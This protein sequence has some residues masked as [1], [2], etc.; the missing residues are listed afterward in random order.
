MQILTTRALDAAA[1]EPLLGS[2]SSGLGTGPAAATA[3]APAAAKPSVE[4]LRFAHHFGA[5]IRLLRPYPALVLTL[6][7]IAEAYVVAEG[8]RGRGSYCML[9]IPGPCTLFSLPAGADLSFTPSP[10]YPLHWNPLKWAKWPDPSTSLCWTARRRGLPPPWRM[11]PRCMVPP[12]RS[13]LPR[14]M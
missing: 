13:M 4:G 7:A 5:L 9:L 3:A 1:T 14:R 2:R 6:L 8:G 10:L 12:L 11:R